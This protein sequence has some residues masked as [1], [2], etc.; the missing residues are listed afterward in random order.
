MLHPLLS[1]KSFNPVLDCEGF[2]SVEENTRKVATCVMGSIQ[3]SNWTKDFLSI[4][5]NRSFVNDNGSFDLTPNVDFLTNLLI[6]K[7]WNASSISLSYIDQYMTIY[8]SD[9]FCP[10]QLSRKSFMITKT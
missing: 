9:F 7:G 6:K 3:Y 8:P 2:V 5:A 10:K 1:I 4:Y